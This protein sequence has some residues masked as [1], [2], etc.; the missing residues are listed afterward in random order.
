[1]T[2]SKTQL[3][4]LVV[5]GLCL[6]TSAYGQLTPSADAYTN[7]AASTTNYGANALL[8]VESGSQ[9]TYIQ[10]NLSSIPAGYAS[11]NIAKATLKL[12]VNA[13]TTAGNFNVN[14]VNGSWSEA[15]I[16]A[17]SSPFG[18]HDCHCGTA[19]LCKYERV[20]PHR[21]HFRAAGMA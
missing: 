11:N 15:T 12:Y 16:T 2:N 10:F 7:T 20:H 14:Y 21:H 6:L 1:M 3:A 8:D 4:V 17:K 13:V 9:T 18:R 19:H 5:S